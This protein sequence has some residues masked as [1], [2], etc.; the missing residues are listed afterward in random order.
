MI[1][2]GDQAFV[3]VAGHPALWTAGG[4]LPVSG[5]FQ[6]DG[7]IT[8]PATVTVLRAGYHPVLH[9]SATAALPARN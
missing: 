3:M 5:P 9:S 6:P 2:A 4:Y 8:P 1:T 7:L